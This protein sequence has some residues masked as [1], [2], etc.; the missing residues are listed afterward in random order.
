MLSSRSTIIVE[1]KTATF[2]GPS[3]M[4]YGLMVVNGTGGEG[5]KKKSQEFQLEMDCVCS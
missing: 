1:F 3:I 4:G 2:T 5:S